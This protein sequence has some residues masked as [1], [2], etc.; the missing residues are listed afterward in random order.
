MLLCLYLLSI[1][2]RLCHADFGE[3]VCAP[4]FGPMLTEFVWVKSDERR[5]DL[6]DVSESAPTDGVGESER[7]RD[8]SRRMPGSEARRV[9]AV[10]FWLA[11]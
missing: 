9:F 1:V 8:C 11:G 6:G 3:G 4:R 7:L 5:G 10:L 2:V